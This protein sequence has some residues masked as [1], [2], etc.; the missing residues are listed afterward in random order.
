MRKPI[1]SEAEAS[2]SFSGATTVV[3]LVLML[4]ATLYLWRTGYMRRRTAY[5]TIAILVIALVAF[6]VYLHVSGA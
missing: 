6:G 3:V 2:Q 5:S 4:G 1:G